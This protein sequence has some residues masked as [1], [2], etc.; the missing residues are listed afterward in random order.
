MKKNGQRK[1]RKP[2]PGGNS[3]DPM[4][5]L[6]LVFL[7]GKGWK[8]GEIKHTQEAGWVNILT[9]SGGT[10]KPCLIKKEMEC[11]GEKMKTY[12]GGDGEG[13]VGHNLRGG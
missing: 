2:K 9:T 8:D 4:G 1:K 5:K 11:R 6:K 3:W 7:N 10:G 12:E 13:K